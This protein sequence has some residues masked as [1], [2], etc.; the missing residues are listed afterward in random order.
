M[1]YLMLSAVQDVATAPADVPARDILYTPCI[2][3][4]LR[5]ANVV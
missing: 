5:Q 4:G 3:I 1:M 2:T